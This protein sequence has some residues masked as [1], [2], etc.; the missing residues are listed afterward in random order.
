[1]L[2]CKSLAKIG[3]ADNRMYADAHPTLSTIQ[4]R[5][6]NLSEDLSRIATNNDEL[7]MLLY[8]IGNDKKY[9]EALFTEYFTLDTIQRYNQFEFDKIPKNIDS[10]L[11]FFLI[12]MDSDHSLQ[13]MTTKVQ[14]SFEDIQVAYKSRATQKLKEILGDDDLLGIKKISAEELKSV[15]D[16]IIEGVQKMDRYRY[17]I[18][19][20]Q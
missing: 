20:I 4:I 13:V 9:N 7:V 2:G 17:I 6:E 1:M 3:D 16:F 18:R 12:E 19:I 8:T 11:L 10:D 15:N 5:A 14:A